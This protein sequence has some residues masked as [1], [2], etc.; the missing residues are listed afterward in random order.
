MGS[1][2]SPV[3]DAYYFSHD[4]GLRPYGRTEEF[5][6]FFG[7]I[8]GRI[9]SDILSTEGKSRPATVLD[10]G[11]AWGLLVEAL[12]DRGIDAYGVDI[13]KY[14][15]QNVP[16]RISAYCWVG[17]VTDPFPQEY[18]LIVC[19]EVVEH[20]PKAEAEKAIEDIC[21]YTDDVLFSSTPFDYKEVTH[22][23]VQP[24]EY[25]AELFAHQ[26][27]FRD[28]D[29]DASFI[30]PWAV[31]FRRKLEPLAHLVRDYER[32]FFLL[33]KENSEL[34]SLSLEMRQ[35][36]AG[37]EEQAKSL[38]ESLA[39]VLNSKS[40]KLTGPLRWLVSREK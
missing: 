27:F 8:A 29:F 24:P 30:T 19:I 40:W 17:S 10:A 38:R 23:N 28:L 11:C 25:W 39:G 22:L 26:G 21:R 33:S 32:R 15:I 3:F 18:D 4:C 37:L 1:Q 13:S 5:L 7:S 14:A 9:V 31:R 12:R 36:I 16:P 35:H 34:R 20:M 6:R 2:A